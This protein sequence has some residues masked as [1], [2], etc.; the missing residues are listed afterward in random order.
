MVFK[1]TIDGQ[2]VLTGCITSKERVGYPLY[3][4]AKVKISE[5]SLATAVWMLS[6]DSTQEIDNLEAY[7]DK[8]NTAYGQR[9]HLSHH[10]FI[11]NPFQYYQPTGWEETYY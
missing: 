6:E 3:T 4:E 10:V 2:K 1:A 5:S 8:I 9:L 11:R 7:G